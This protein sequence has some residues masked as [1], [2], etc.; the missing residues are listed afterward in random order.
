MDYANDGERKS[1][2]GGVVT[3]GGYTT[4]MQAIVSLSSTEAEYIA[5]GSIMQEVLFQRQILN[6]LIGEKYKKK[7]SYMKTI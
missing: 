2:S 1:V 4:K 5:L 7:A 3:L 6:K